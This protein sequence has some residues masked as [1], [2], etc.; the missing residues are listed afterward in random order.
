[1]H[2]L[3]A[4]A[5]G[6][7]KR[8]VVDRPEMVIGSG[9]ACDIRLPYAGVGAAHARLRSEGSLLTIEDLGS[10][11]GVLV[12]GRRAREATMLNVLDEIRLGQVALLIEDVVP[13]AKVVAPAA[14][15]PAPAVTIT[16]E[17]FLEHI[18]G[19]SRWVQSDSASSRTLESLLTA[20]LD[21]FGGGVIFLFQGSFPFPGSG[22]APALEARG[23]E[24]P[25][26]KFVVASQALWL[27]TGEA[28]LEQVRA[29]GDEDGGRGA[30]EGSLAGAP[31]WI[32]FQTFEA[33]ERPY[34]F[35]VALPRFQGAA[36]SPLAGFR[37]LGDLLVL[38]LVHHVGQFQPIVF[39]Q[40]E[41][42]DLTL[43]PGL[44]VGE[45]PAMKRV[46]EHLRMAV[47]PP[48]NVLLRGEAGVSKALLASSLHLSGPS[49][50]GPFV[51][52]H[53]G[54]TPEQ[55]LEAELFGAEVDG[56]DGVLVREGKLAAADKGTLFL[57]EVD[58][59]PFALQGRLVRFLR[60]GEVTPAGAAVAQ[61]A[62]VRLITA[63]RGPLEALVAR[64][65]FRV[66]LAYLLAQLTVDVPALRERR[67]DLPLLIQATINRCC[68]QIGKRVQGIALKALEA[69]VVYEY[70]GNLPELENIVRRLV[71]LC[72]QGRPIDATMLP[73]AVRRATVKGLVTDTTGDLD[74]ERLVAD[75]E[76]AAIREALRRSAGNKSGAARALGLS[77]NGLAMKIRR[78]GLAEPGRGGDA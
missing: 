77:R 64:D 59:L 73:D 28:V 66:D 65:Q 42:P 62:R 67:E 44:V 39:S 37:T 54:G 35:A 61:R 78:L 18:A 23:L 50:D 60:T 31:A 2:R 40:R 34:L 36:W 53:V 27:T 71:H 33:H 14:E 57:D 58:T 5:Q 29:D 69:L 56:K 55:Q 49:R 72:P 19:V 46:L 51:T 43:A 70:P 25:S 76:R 1:M 52:A 63:S 41:Q 16:A 38:G 15:P 6:G 20:V 8:F 30:F 12:N 10:R 3:V 75:C 22:E 21:D 26:I 32:A 4:Y 9:E 24:M 48:V 13:A 17:R 45:S 11:K 68:H 74:L 47:E 7:V